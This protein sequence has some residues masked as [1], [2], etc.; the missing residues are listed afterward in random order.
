MLIKKIKMNSNHKD[1]SSIG[2]ILKYTLPVIYLSIFLWPK[3]SHGQNTQTSVSFTLLRH[4]TAVLEYGDKLFLIDPMLA[5]K[6]EL[7][8][9]SDPTNGSK[10]GK[11]PATSIPDSSLQMLQRITHILLTHNHLDHFDTRA[12]S[13]LDK[14]I[15]IIC[16]QE[17]RI[18]LERQ[19]FAN[20]KAIKGQIKLDEIQ[21]TRRPGKHGKNTLEF[22]MGPSSSFLI[23]Q[24]RFPTVFVGGDV[25]LTEDLSVF[26]EKEK[27]DVLILNGGQATFANGEPVT[28]GMQDAKQIAELLPHSEII[29]VHMDEIPFCK[30]SRKELLRFLDVNAIENVSV[31]DNGSIIR[32]QKNKHE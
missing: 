3:A 21:I 15:P 1:E 25:L 13:L 10:L 23:S 2:T 26:L 24:P 12:A 20:I 17:D 22:I 14:Q 11:M 16:Q 28:L 5:S 6:G 18:F 30:V 7:P 29:V 19:G 9:Y 27:P 31:P 32:I 8:F 4:A